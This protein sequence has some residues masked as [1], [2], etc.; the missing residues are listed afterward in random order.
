TAGAT[1]KVPTAEEPAAGAPATEQP[2]AGPPGA[3]E[4][5]AEEP[6]AE[7][8]AS[9]PTGAVRPT[10]GAPVSR[11]PV[12]GP[13]VPTSP[14]AP[15]LWPRVLAAVAV[16]V[17]GLTAA[18]VTRRDA[19]HQAAQREQLVAE[20]TGNLAVSTVRQ[21]EAAASGVSGLPDADGNVARG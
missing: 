10:A 3:E 5:T 7:Q 2:A 11:P 6:T 21:L 16:V 20:Q 4:P 19:A 14:R 8:P 17:I 9:G 12:A 18:F 15:G 13:P 1:A